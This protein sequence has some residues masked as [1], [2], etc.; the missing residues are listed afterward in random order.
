[1]FSEIA[2]KYD[3]LNRFLSFGMSAKWKAR[4]VTG[5][6]IPSK[7]FIL[8]VC[9]GSGDLALGFVRSRPEFN[10]YVTAIDFSAPMI[11]QAR[12]RVAK[13]GAPYPRRVDFIMGDALDLNFDDEKFDLV[14]VGFGVRNFARLDDGLSEMTR[15]LKVG[16]QLNVIEFFRDG[17][18]FRPF[19]WYLDTIVPIL[20]NL[21]SRSKA[22]TYLIHSTRDF[23]SVDE[24]EALLKNLGYENIVRER[25]IFG[26][27]HIVRAT[28]GRKE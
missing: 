4:L 20:G 5:A 28:K 17:I 1:M 26:V 9:T 23:V 18:T 22:Y 7:G 6:E 13:L 12:E 21:I 10:G 19:Q 11:D 15:V 3:F 16:G 25:M 2:G 8:D 27:A 14:S 24:F